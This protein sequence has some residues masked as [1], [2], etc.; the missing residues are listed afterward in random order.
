MLPTGKE[1]RENI[2]ASLFRNLIAKPK[3]QESTTKLLR[4]YPSLLCSSLPP[5]IPQNAPGTASRQAYQH[6]GAWKSPISPKTFEIVLVAR[7]F[8]PGA[9]SPLPPPPP[10]PSRSE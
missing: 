5:P 10:F 6:R 3:H 9:T 1:V 7:A 8:Q 4:N 2:Q